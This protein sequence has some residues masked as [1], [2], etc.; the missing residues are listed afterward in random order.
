MHAELNLTVAEGLT[1]EEGHDIATKVRHALLHNLRF[2][3]GATIHVDP[4]N[5]SGEQY[6]RIEDHAH[7][8][9]PVHSHP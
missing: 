9:S 7:G 1:V 5:A 3:S 2:L 6:H 4:P 8:D